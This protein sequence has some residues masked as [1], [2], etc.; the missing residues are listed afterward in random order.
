V[1][2]PPKFNVIDITGCHGDLISNCIERSGIR[3]NYKS[4]PAS[5]ISEKVIFVTYGFELYPRVMALRF[6]NTILD[7]YNKGN[8]D[9]FNS[10]K[11]HYLGNISIDDPNSITYN[12]WAHH[13]V[14]SL[15][16]VGKYAPLNG[17]LE[18]LIVDNNARDKTYYELPLETLINNSDAA[19]KN[20][21]D[22]TQTSWNNSVKAYCLEWLV[23]DNLRLRPWLE[24]FEKVKIE[25]ENNN[26]YPEI[27]HVKS[28]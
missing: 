24:E 19:I 8:T 6:L 25:A 3:C 22:W 27:K 13:T 26:L 7:Q 23:K 20:I 16:H 2:I 14:K 5:D 21:E 12:D 9:S 10:W 18:T 28:Y 17:I 4:S 11:K 15:R 1:I